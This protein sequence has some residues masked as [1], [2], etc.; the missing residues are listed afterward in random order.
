[1]LLFL[2]WLPSKETWTCLHT[3]DFGARAPI[4]KKGEQKDSLQAWISSA[5][6]PANK[7]TVTIMKTLQ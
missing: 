5:C 2:N 1:M 7:I 4:K 6:I 3:Q